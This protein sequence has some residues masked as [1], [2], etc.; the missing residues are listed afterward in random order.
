MSFDLDQLPQGQEP[1]P[2]VQIGA[3]V[4]RAPAA[5]LDVHAIGDTRVQRFIDHM[6]ATMRARNGAGLAA[7]Q[8]S[9]PLRICVMEVDQN[10]RYPYKP[11]IPLTVLIN[12][13]IEELGEER[14]ANYEGCLSVPNLRGVVQRPVH[15]R[16]RAMGRK[17]DTIDQEVFGLS[18][19]TFQHECDHLDGT[20]FVDRV[21]DPRTLCTWE[22]FREYHERE[23]VERAEA[24]NARF[25]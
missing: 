12:P 8:I 22:T 4:L 2:V 16:V 3:P 1:S 11:K 10:P 13:L 19:G 6:I 5:E 18:A 9:V 23:F 25:A 20:L 7:P 24:L 15:V 14:F 21:L 17:G